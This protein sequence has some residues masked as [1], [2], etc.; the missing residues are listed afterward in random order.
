MKQTFKIFFDLQGKDR[1][2]LFE[3]FSIVSSVFNDYIDWCFKNNSISK[4]KAHKN[5]YSNLRIKYPTCPSALVQSIRDTALESVKATKFK[6]RPKKSKLSSIRYDKRTLRFEGNRLTFSSIDKRIKV[7]LKLSNYFLT[8]TNCLKRKGGSVIGYDKTKNLFFVCFIYESID[9]PLKSQG[10]VIGLDRG[11]KNLITTS[12][13]KILGNNIKRIKRIHTHLRQKLSTKGTRSAHRLLKRLSGKEARFS[14][15]INHCVSKLL[16]EEK[17]V[18]FFVLEILEGISRGKKG[19][20]Q[21]NRWLSGWPFFQFEMFLTYKCLF[22]G[23]KVVY[24]DPRYTSQ[25]CSVCGYTHKRNRNR[26]TFKCLQCG[27]TENSDKNAAKNI[28]NKF[29]L[30]NGQA[31][32]QGLSQEPIRT[33]DSMKVGSSCSRYRP[34]AGIA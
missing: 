34:C 29:L 4:L 23:I 18:M 30:T 33:E 28:R 25:M 13:G 1:T 5:L 3:T 27:H 26:S 32:L 17:D 8:K 2:D 11:L 24:I 22:K 20:R 31:R 6:F 12:E 9:N 19:S 14:R 16:S 10:K 15:D 21:F 7:D